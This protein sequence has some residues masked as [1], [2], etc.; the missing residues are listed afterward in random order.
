MIKGLDEILQMN[1]LLT[2]YQFNLILLKSKADTKMIS[3]KICIICQF[4]EI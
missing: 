1:L 4:D 3:E 2:N